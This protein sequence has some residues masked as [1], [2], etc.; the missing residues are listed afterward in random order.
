MQKQKLNYE[1]PVVETLV[2]RFEGNLLQ[3][4]SNNPQVLSLMGTFGADDAAG[5]DLIIDKGFD[6]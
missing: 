2:V 6:L 5:D 4:P 1:T 3:A